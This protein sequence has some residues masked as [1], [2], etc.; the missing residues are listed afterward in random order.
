[1]LLVVI[2]KL[3]TNKQINFIAMESYTPTTTLVRKLYVRIRKPVKIQA[4]KVS[5]SNSGTPRRREREALFGTKVH[6]QRCRDINCDIFTCIMDYEKALDSI[7][8]SKLIII[9]HKIP[10]DEKDIHFIKNL[11]WNTMRILK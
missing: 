2:N 3:K 9:L 8:H 7:Q 5:T 4:I 1:M 6:F 11:Y 10:F